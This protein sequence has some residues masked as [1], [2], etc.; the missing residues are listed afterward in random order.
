MATISSAGAAEGVDLTKVMSNASLARLNTETPA[1]APV[2]PTE[3]I[4]DISLGGMRQSAITNLAETAARLASNTL[5]S[6]TVASSD[7]PAAVTASS[8][9]QASVGNYKIEVAQIASAQVTSTATFS[10]LSTVVALGSLNIEKGSW[11]AAL[12]TFAPNPNW[13]KA[14]VVLGPKNDTLDRVR[15]KI[16]AAGLGVIATVVSDATGSRLVL[17]STNTGADNGFKITTEEADASSL[18]PPEDQDVVALSS[19]GFDPASMGT[20][21]MQLLQS[22]SN[23]QTRINDEPVE[24]PLN[25]IESETGLSLILKSPTDP[26]ATISIE[27]D[28]SGMQQA[29]QNFAQAYNALQSLGGSVANSVQRSTR[30]LL[31]T[32]EQPTESGRTLAQAGT[33]L[34]PAG[35]LQIDT[36]RLASALQQDP[37]AVRES[38]A[39]LAQQVLAD[40][41]ARPDTTP[42]DDGALPQP[43]TAAPAENPSSNAAGTLL[44]QRLLDEYQVTPPQT[45]LEDNDPSFLP[46]AFRA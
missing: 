30:S 13:P 16:N 29:T 43:L 18:P 17:R 4:A 42:T 34:S 14:T 12:A 11:D 45:E 3:D 22:A 36:Q 35:T 39:M 40:L 2:E 27:P 23:A 19:L 28:W 44:R 20:S 33:T 9:P 37:A 26:P 15:D 8:T 46:P 21:G 7:A 24:S 31:G 6:S 32:P 5:W 25:A 41:P 1:Q 38:Q 10:S